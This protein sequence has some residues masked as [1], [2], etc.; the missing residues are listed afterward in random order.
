M[1]DEHQP[2]FAAVRADCPTATWSR[3]VELVRADA[4]VGEKAEDDEAV[5]RVR[6]RGGLVSPKVTLFPDDPDWD[7]EC[8]NLEH[9]CEH[10]AAAVIAWKRSREAGEALPT[11]QFET[12]RV[13]YRLSREGGSVAL[14][15]V[16]VTGDREEPFRGRLE[17]LATGWSGTPFVAT[18]EDLA[19]EAALGPHR[20][21]RLE[22]ARLKRIFLKLARCEDVKLDASSVKVSGEK[23]LPRG[24]VEDRGEGFALTLC[25]D[26]RVTETFDNDIVLCGTTLHVA[27]DP[28][29]S[30]REFHELRAG[31]YFDPDDLSELMTEILP[32]LKRRIPVD[33]E[34]DRLPETTSEQ[35]RMQ[36]EMSREGRILSV[37]ATIVYGEPPLAR[38]DGGKLVPLQGVVPLRDLKGERLETR[39]LER[40]GLRPGIRARFDGIEAVAFRRRLAGAESDVRGE[41]LEYFDLAPPLVPSVSVTGEG[42]FGVNFESRGAE[43][44]GVGT[45]GRADPADVVSAW[46]AGE[47]LVPLL[48]GGWAPL[49]VDWLEKFGHRIADLLAARDESG[50]VPRACLPG[51]AQLCEDL[52]E[53]VPPQLARL[54]SVMEGFS[55]IEASRLPEDLATSLRDYQRVGVDWLVFLRDVGMGAM[56]ADDMGLGK[57]LQALCVIRGRTLVVAPTSVLQNWAAEIRRHRPGLPHAIYH[58]PRRRL[59]PDAEVTLTTYAILRLDSGKLAAES[60]DVVILDE[61]QNIKNADSQV[62]AAAYGLDAEFRL[63]LTGTPVENRLEELWSQFHFTNRGLL[64]GLSDFRANY[65]GPIAS[66]DG[67]AA[68]RL[69]SKIRPFVLRRLKSEVAQELPPRT[70]MVLRCELSE[71]ER[72]VYEAIR[73]ATLTE[74]MKKLDAGGGV[75]AALEA[76]LRLRQASCHRGLVPGQEAEGS[77]KIEL[78]LESLENVV[79]EGHKALVFSQWTSL[80]DR[81]EPHLS[82]ASIDF[83]RLDGSTRDRAAVV[84]RFQDDSGPPLML[85]SLKAGGTGLNLTAADHVFLLDPWWNPAVEDQAADRAH[86]IGQDR[87]VMVYRMVAA[88]TVEERILEL[89]ESKRALADVALGGADQAGGL[90]RDDLADLL[91]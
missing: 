15:R 20:S 12:G 47:S 81:V 51:V 66:G 40:L 17:T 78:L 43:S 38:V 5:F 71:A 14:C 26:P 88:E 53:P 25:R 68:G 37:L 42:G 83:V 19:A 75:L 50:S 9:A 44:S 7:C 18:P 52:D 70:D 55:G 77:S 48:E 85:I 32:A 61:A 45:V 82:S 2:L 54:R 74:V 49:P 60:W 33:V 65:S 73:A 63:T 57:T 16:I 23:V 62:A 80:L 4:V 56:L 13:G 91:R 28:G 39:K 22:P 84:E 30:G 27:G 89:Q 21:G 29:L 72:E 24:R 10:V 79:A 76:L 34:T 6:T 46:R 35:P 67:D 59:D 58:G 90:T 69:R 64:G 11:P 1:G 36:L 87:P 8:G 41:G 3:G 86:R 31:R